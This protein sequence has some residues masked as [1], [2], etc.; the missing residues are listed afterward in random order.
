[1]AAFL[2]QYAGGCLL[3]RLR[4]VSHE[5]WQVVAVALFGWWWQP[6]WDGGIFR[7]CLEL[8]LCCVVAD[9][10]AALVQASACVEAYYLIGWWLGGWG[11]IPPVGWVWLSPLGWRL[12]VLLAGG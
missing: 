11:M 1:M 8:P 12:R 7:C 6:A 2:L 5:L 3:R 4:D 9:T 10:P